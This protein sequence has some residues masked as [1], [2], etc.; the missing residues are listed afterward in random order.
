MR[1]ASVFATLAAT[2]AV[3][4]AAAQ[5]SM[6]PRS[7]RPAGSPGA[8]A[9]TRSATPPPTVAG[10]VVTA[11]IRATAPGF[12]TPTGSAPEAQV[13]A[14]ALQG[15]STLTSRFYLAQDLSRQEILS[16]DFVLPAG[17]LVFH[18]GG[19]K[20]YVIA[21]PKAQ[22]YLV[23]DSEAL[24]NALE[25]GAGIVN[26]QYEAKVQ[27]T[28]DRK[29]I[30]GLPSRKSIVTVTYVS[31]IPFEN[32]RV[33]VQQKND[34]EVWHTSALVSSAATDHF[35]FKFHKT[36]ATEIGFPMEVDLR[37]VM[38]GLARGKPAAAPKAATLQ[39]G[40]LHM[41]VTE[42]KKEPKLDSELFRIPPAGYR[43]LEKNPYFAAGALSP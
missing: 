6:T 11:E 32:D 17:T 21:D 28:D 8:P 42:V 7:P 3:S 20:F 40:S 38:G 25:G 33:L 2:A 31:S 43:R 1:A 35:F 13:M 37:V 9:A 24:L 23:M 16:T 18:K 39:P 22:T 36:V 26:T 30:A 12:K 41:V 4:A 34:L 5:T 27:H 10:Y 29:M 14:G 15:M 19:D